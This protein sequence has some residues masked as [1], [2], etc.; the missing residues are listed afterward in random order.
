VSGLAQGA[1]ADD[2]GHA[3]ADDGNVKS[4]AA[5]LHARTPDA[6]HAS[7]SKDEKQINHELANSANWC[8]F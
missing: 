1:G 7:C 2:A 3:D 6:N 8:L 4:H 5:N